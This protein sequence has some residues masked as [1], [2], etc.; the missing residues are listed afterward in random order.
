MRA[1]ERD[2]E[3]KGGIGDERLRSCLRIIY[4]LIK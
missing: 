2:E 4:W 1:E 3:E